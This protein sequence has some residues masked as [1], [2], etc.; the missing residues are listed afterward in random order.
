[1]KKISKRKIIKALEVCAKYD[2][3]D[4]CPL[5][6]TTGCLATK[7]AIHQIEKEPV[8][9]DWDGFINN[10]FV[11]NVKTQEEYNAFMKECEEH[12]LKWGYGDATSIDAFS[13]YETD[14]CIAHNINLLYSFISFYQEDNIPVV[15]YKEYIENEP[16]P[17]GNDTSSSNKNI[18]HL[19]D[20]TLLEICQ[21]GLLNI[22]NKIAET[23]DGYTFGYVQA[24]IDVIEKLKAGEKDG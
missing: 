24:V 23:G 8:G 7:N 2:N 3:C 5:N 4:N 22:S 9:F 16:A 19:D 10:K 12:G 15:S 13:E 20:S 18:T 21:E 17:S 11:V 14:T 1:M 6:G